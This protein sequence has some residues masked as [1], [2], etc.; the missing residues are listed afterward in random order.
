MIRSIPGA[1][2]L[3]AELGYA[4]MRNTSPVVPV[5]PL[6]PGTGKMRW[7][8]AHEAAYEVGRVRQGRQSVRA[9]MPV[10]VRRMQ[11]L[12]AEWLLLADDTVPV[13]REIG[14]KRLVLDVHLEAW[15]EARAA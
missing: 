8:D 6:C 1:T 5:A 13:V 10:T 4:S 2:V 14:R 3:T 7:L 15:C 9:G 11:Q 12:M